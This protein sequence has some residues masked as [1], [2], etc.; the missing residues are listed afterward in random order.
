[1]YVHMCACVPVCMYVHVCVCVSTC[2]FAGKFVAGVL[3]YK[4]MVDE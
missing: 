4:A 3:D 2:R 1:M